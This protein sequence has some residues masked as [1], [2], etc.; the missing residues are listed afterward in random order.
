MDENW[1]KQT[2]PLIVAPTHL[3]NNFNEK[4]RKINGTI[5]DKGVKK[6]TP[7]C[8]DYMDIESSNMCINTLECLDPQF[9][10]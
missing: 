7:V 10:N 4:G 1:K 2:M 6:E 5:G 3:Y 8:R 9:T